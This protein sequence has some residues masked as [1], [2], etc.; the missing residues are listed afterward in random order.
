MEG[1]HCDGNKR[2]NW[3]FLATIDVQ[4]KGRKFGAMFREGRGQSKRGYLSLSSYTWGVRKCG[5]QTS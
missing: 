5:D 1:V 3:Q 4:I 2:R